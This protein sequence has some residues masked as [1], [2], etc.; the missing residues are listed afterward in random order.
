MTVS[1][2]SPTCS[3]LVSRFWSDPVMSLRSM[4][5]PSAGAGHVSTTMRVRLGLWG[6]LKNL[7]G[8]DH[9]GNGTSRHE[10]EGC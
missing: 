10:V 9:N 6:P 8:S 7:Q 4:R 1:K 5:G 3:H 2:A